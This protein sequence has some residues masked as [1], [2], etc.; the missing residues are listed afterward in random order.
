MRKPLDASALVGR[1]KERLEAL[2]LSA[3]KASEKTGYG[4]DLIRNIE[5]SAKLG[6]PHNA[7]TDTL[8]ALA[9][10]LQVSPEWLIHGDSEKISGYGS[11]LIRFNAV[12]A[13]MIVRGFVQAGVWQEVGAMDQTECESYSA[14]P[15]SRYSAAYQFLLIVRGDSMDAA[16][17]VPIRSGA[18]LKCVSFDAYGGQVQNGQ[19]AVIHRFREAGGLCEATVKRVRITNGQIEFWPESTNKAHQPIRYPNGGRS[20]TEDIQIAAIV[21]DVIFRVG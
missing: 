7:R 10:V 1:I 17:P 6:K 9:V 14:L 4:P 15:D 13:A 16:E 18:L 5:R 19:I 8:N 12:P 2:N 21:L 11:D 3:R 20:E